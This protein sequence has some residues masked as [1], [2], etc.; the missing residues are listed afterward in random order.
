MSLSVGADVHEKD[1]EA[2][3]CAVENHQ[4]AAAALLLKA[5]ASVSAHQSCALYRTARMG[6]A[7]MLE[8]LLT[9]GADVHGTQETPLCLAA[10][11]GHIKIVRLLLAA[12]ADP[13]AAWHESDPSARRRMVAPLE[14][15]ADAMTPQRRAD[16]VAT[17]PQFAQLVAM[18]HASEHRPRLC[19]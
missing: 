14:A 4:V 3:L 17:S 2:L 7:D 16:L 18:V 19:R 13:V 1:K 9:A 8:M 12:G 11:I 10:A 6:H 15:C 5:G